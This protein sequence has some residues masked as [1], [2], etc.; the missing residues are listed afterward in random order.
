[1][2]PQWISGPLWIAVLL[3]ACSTPKPNGPITAAFDGVYK[4]N[5][6]SVSSPDWGCLAVQPNDTLSVAG[7]YATFS[8]LSGWV[9]PGVA[10]A[11]SSQIAHL[12]GQFQ[13]GHF[14]GLLQ[15]H[16][17]GSDRLTCGYTLKLDREIS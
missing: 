11:L 12:Q 2:K 7:G 13:G 15:F 14:E 5:G 9:A 16:E 17:R 8:D 4:G 10:A 1:M 6:Y 3:M